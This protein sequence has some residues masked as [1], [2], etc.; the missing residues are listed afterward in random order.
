MSREQW[1]WSREQW[2]GSSGHGSVDREEGVEGRGAVVKARE[3]L[4]G[5]IWLGTVGISY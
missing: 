2:T 1:A 3:K 5:S 4:A